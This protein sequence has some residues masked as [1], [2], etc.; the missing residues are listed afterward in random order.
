MDLFSTE[1]TV[2]GAITSNCLVR[3]ITYRYSCNEQLIY[4]SDAISRLAYAVEIK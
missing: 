2:P 4:N 1:A 3:V